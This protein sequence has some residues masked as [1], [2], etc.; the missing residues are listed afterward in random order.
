MIRLD[1]KTIVVT[2]GGRGI[3]AA[4][5]ELLTERGATVV[6]ADVGVDI[7]GVGVDATAAEAVVERIVSKG[8]RAV[9]CVA[10]LRS[11]DGIEAIRDS[12]LALGARVDG[13][14]NNAGIL[15][16]LPFEEITADE[17]QRQMDVHLLGSLRL[18]QQLW[19]HLVESRGKIVN[20]TSSG[21]FGAPIS[22]AYSMAK[23]AVFAFTRS[24]ATL[25]AQCGVSVNLLMPGAET[26]MQSF[27]RQQFGGSSEPS[28][29]EQ[30]RSSPEHVAAVLTYLMSDEC[31]TSGETIY[32]GHGH[33]RRI[34]LASGPGFHSEF[35][36]PEDVGRNWPTALS[37]TPFQPLGTLSDFR[38]SLSAPLVNV[39][40]R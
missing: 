21:I 24:L 32:A 6:V 14:V 12:A 4:H 19:P 11:P 17:I 40:D 7:G 18:T 33:V 30:R 31:Q 3:G 26:R 15:S 29:E 8:G 2:G 27:S 23:G 5:A 36:T 1:G 38:D 10:D 25:G 28:E 37:L 22:M 34:V 20:T 35:L 16:H 9:A 13:L 39:T